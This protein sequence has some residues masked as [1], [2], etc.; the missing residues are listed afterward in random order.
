MQFLFTD[1]IALTVP[2]AAVLSVAQVDTGFK[3]KKNWGAHVVMSKE[4]RMFAF[5]FLNDTI[6]R[7]DP[8]VL[9]HV[10]VVGHK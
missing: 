8:I 9:T 4:F 10:R 2:K 5:V 3:K 7:D 1:R 6:C